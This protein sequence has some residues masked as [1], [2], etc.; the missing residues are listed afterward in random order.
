MW[1]L[2]WMKTDTDTK[3]AAVGSRLNTLDY[4]YL[5]M[6]N[7][8]RRMG[9]YEASLPFL[10]IEVNQEELLTILSD[11]NLDRLTKE[12]CQNYVKGYKV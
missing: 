8:Q 1:K 4:R 5:C 6:F 10:E 7:Y 3:L 2:K 12:Q 11:K 9:A